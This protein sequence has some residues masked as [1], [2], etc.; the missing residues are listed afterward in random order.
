MTTV[1]KDT[2]DGAKNITSG[3]GESGVT[4]AKTLQDVADDVEVLRAAFSALLV[5][6]DTDFTAQNI[7]V[8][9]SQLDED[10]QSTGEVLASAILT[11]KGR[12]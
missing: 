11:K 3:S 7:A 12:T 2:Y 4:L 5:K 9:S 10:Y 1:N 6:M 8:T